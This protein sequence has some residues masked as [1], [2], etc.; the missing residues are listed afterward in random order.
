MLD[1]VTSKNFKDIVGTN[2]VLTIMDGPDVT[3]KV[4]EVLEIKV[5]KDDDRPGECR[6]KPFTVILSGPKGHQARDGCYA[7]SFEKIGL[8]EG[9][10]VDNRSD[11]PETEDFNTEQAQKAAAAKKKAPA[12]AKKKTAESAGDDVAHAAQPEAVVLYEIN[13]G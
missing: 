12:K 2:A 9:V 5:G 13:F 6:K 4:E 11:N 1:K 10:F 8:L 3:L 7:V